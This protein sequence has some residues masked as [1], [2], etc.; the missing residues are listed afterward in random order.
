[1][2]SV[3]NSINKKFE[4]L[5][6]YHMKKIIGL[7][8]ILCMLV[9]TLTMS[10][11]AAPTPTLLWEF[12]TGTGIEDNMGANSA[13][14]GV[15]YAAE[16]FYHIFTA[17]AADPNVSIDLTATDVSQIQWV[18]A[19]V[20]NKS[21]ATAI[22]LY[23]ACDGKSLSGPECTHID[24]LP[25]SDVWQTVIVN[26]PASN[27]ATANAI[28]AP[29][30]PLTE[31]FWTG[32]VDWIRLDPMWKLGDDGLDTTGGNMKADEQIYIDYIAFFSTE[33]DAKAY[34][35]TDEAAAAADTT[36]ATT[37]ETPAAA[38]TS[39]VTSIAVIAAVLALG[40]AYVVSKKR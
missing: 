40:T 30:V 11:F 9:A 26:I 25:S 18:K 13:A 33:A 37:T 39:D 3:L 2:N 10:A 38:Q 22:E 5:V 27:I 14:N 17:T 20:L 23:G 15:T 4:R 8:L 31:T 36:T 1:M 29:A 32:S 35:G 16:N 28:K 24:I 19:R 12:G 21:S 34:V 6:I 7:S